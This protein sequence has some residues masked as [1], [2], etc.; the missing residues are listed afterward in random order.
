MFIRWLMRLPPKNNID[1]EALKALVEAEMSSRGI[2]TRFI[3]T[4]SPGQAIELARNSAQ[5]G[6]DAVVAVGGDGTVNEVVNGLAGS[7]I[8]L[9]I[10][11]CG[12]ANV[13]AAELQIPSQISSA[14]SVIAQGKIKIIDLGI[15]NGRAFTMMAGIGFDAHVVRLVDRELKGRWGGFSYVIVALR[16]LV[17]YSLRRIEVVTDTG[18]RLAGYYIFIQN[19]SRYGSGF[20]ASPGSKIDDGLLEVIIFPKRR[21]FILVRYLLSDRKDSFDVMRRTIRWVDV[22]TP[23]EIQIDGD[24]YCDGPARIEVRPAVLK[25]IVP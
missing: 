7:P 3:W 23:H 14:C 22:L 15:L 10:I 19:A 18:E 16:E 6:Y 21:F 1:P 9:G 20:S 25:V 2:A 8:A 24:Y 11:P 4:S 5:D 17:R 12:T 13:L